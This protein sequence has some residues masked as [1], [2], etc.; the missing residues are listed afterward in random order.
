MIVPDSGLLGGKL[1]TCHLNMYGTGGIRTHA[2]NLQASM[3]L[4]NSSALVTT[5]VFDQALTCLGDGLRAW[6]WSSSGPP[7]PAC[8]SGRRTIISVSSLAGFGR[9]GR[10]HADAGC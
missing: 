7:A 8:G 9:A 1:S 6:S 4:P 10:S 3:A 5:M 2:K